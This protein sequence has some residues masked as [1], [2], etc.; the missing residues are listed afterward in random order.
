MKRTRQRENKG[1]E[2]IRATRTEYGE[3]AKYIHFIVDIFAL[4]KCTKKK[5]KEIRI[6]E[7]HNK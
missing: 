7:I 6:K 5:R 1:G 3:I 2:Q 4:E